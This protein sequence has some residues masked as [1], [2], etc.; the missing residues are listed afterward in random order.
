[1]FGDQGGRDLSGQ[2][3]TSTVGDE[4]GAS[5]TEQEH[6]FL[7]ARGE[8]AVF[9]EMIAKDTV[10]EVYDAARPIAYTRTTYL[11]TEALAYATSRA[12]GAAERV[13]IREYAS[14]AAL[15]DAPLLTGLCALEYKRSEGAMRS[16]MRLWA[17]PR[18]ITELVSSHGS[19]ATSS[20][21]RGDTATL[22]EIVS[23]L[24]VADLRPRVATWYRRESLVGMRR[25]DRVRI[26]LD[27]GI[28][29]LKPCPPGQPGDPVA[30]NPALGT[31]RCRVLEIKYYGDSPKW[32]ESA[33][34]PLTASQT[35]SKFERAMATAQNNRAKTLRST[36]PLQIP[37]INSTKQGD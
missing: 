30:I 3:V 11:D 20:D 27:E 8:A 23:R 32:L 22:R 29:F 36:R 25:G 26:T 24:R 10:R 4:G 13:R 17:D 15:D 14:A 31:V 37:S 1:M 35:F 34:A 9:L 21:R 5:G 12:G 28:R 2:H 6:R 7:L 19:A 33:I 16:K 18:H